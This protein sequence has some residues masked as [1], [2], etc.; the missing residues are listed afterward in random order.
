MKSGLKLSGTIRLTLLTGSLA[1]LAATTSAQAEDGPRMFRQPDASRVVAAPAQ[2]TWS[3]PPTRRGL[4][5]AIF[6]S[7]RQR[8]EPRALGFAPLALPEAPRF[9]PRQASRP[10]DRA[11][12]LPQGALDAQVRDQDPV[13]QR[14]PLKGRRD[15]PGRARSYAANWNNG[16][17]LNAS[18]NYC[19][20]L[21]DGFA[22]PIGFAGRGSDG[23]HEAACQLAC[24]GASTAVF[25]APAGAKDIDEAI[26]AGRP[27]SSLPNAFRYRA[28][29]DSACTCKSPGQTQS[30]LA[31]LTDF[32]L[33]KGDL[34]MTRAGMRHFEGSTRFPYRANQ[35][36]DALARV[37]DKR[38]VALIRGMEAASLRGIITVAAQTHVRQ[39][40]VAEIRNADRLAAR[41]GI[42]EVPR[43]V[44]AFEVVGAS[45]RY[46]PQPVRVVTKRTG[47]VA[48]N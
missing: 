45:R 25:T 3:A 18:T 26:R 47:I 27:Y 7:P 29:Y 30:S 8:Y 6:Q 11:R 42:I 17:G 28:T 13:I 44:R 9:A 5:P 43:V 2:H 34:A 31:L 14:D 4:I 22:F 46:G 35:F 48:L 33:R 19:V 21:C 1:V 37:K 36:A 16:A 38:E 10:R 40:V 41:A 20:R 24:P 32:T 23:A 12:P 15:I 39:R